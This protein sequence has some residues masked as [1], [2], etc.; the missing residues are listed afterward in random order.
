[1][2]PEEP[3]SQPQVTPPGQPV[4]LPDPLGGV[5]VPA[6]FGNVIRVFLS[7]AGAI[8]LLMFVYG[9]IMWILSGG[10]SSKVQAAQKILV[11]STIGIILLFGAYMFTT[12]IV[13]SILGGS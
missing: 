5:T 10:E 2:L 1:M 3:T 4:T 6:F 9:G 13:Q 7:I 8:A 11:N 12:A